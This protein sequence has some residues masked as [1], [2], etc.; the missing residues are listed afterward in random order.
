MQNMQ[1]MQKPVKLC[2]RPYGLVVSVKRCGYYCEL[3]VGCYTVF[4]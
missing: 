2:N 4:E 3:G 1:K